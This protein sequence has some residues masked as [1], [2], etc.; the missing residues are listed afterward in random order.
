MLSFSYV[1]AMSY[2]LKERMVKYMSTPKHKHLKY[3][4][5][6]VIQE[7]LN[8][9][10][11]FTAIATRLGKDRRCIAKEIYKHR[12]LKPAKVKKEPDCP[13]QASHLMSVT[14]AHLKT[15]VKRTNTAMMLP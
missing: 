15:D 11:S 9:N 7:F 12:I 8:L 2:E 5:R 10:H 1:L 13:K 14:A 4:D 6:F 3:E